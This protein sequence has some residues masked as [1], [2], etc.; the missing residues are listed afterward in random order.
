VESVLL[1]LGYG[2]ERLR[3][4]GVPVK[5]IRLTGGGSNSPVWRQMC[6]DIF[7]VPTAALDSGK[8]AAS[9][10]AIQAGWAAG[11]EANEKICLGEISERLVVT[12]SATVCEPVSKNTELYADLLARSNKLRETLVSANLLQ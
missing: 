4:L 11:L 9:G 12:D 10:A 5:S 2:L 3:D 7:G 8:G 1:G 6:A